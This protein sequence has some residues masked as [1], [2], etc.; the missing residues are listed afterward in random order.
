MY[1]LFGF[2]NWVADIHRLYFRFKS[3]SC[4][5]RENAQDAL[6]FLM[7]L[8]QPLFSSSQTSGCHTPT[9]R[10][11]KPAPRLEPSGFYDKSLAK[12]FR[13]PFSG[14]VFVFLEK[15]VAYV[16]SLQSSATDAATQTRNLSQSVAL[17][18]LQSMQAQAHPAF[19]ACI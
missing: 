17:I 8:Q 5:K 10:F 1:L 12:L 15:F 2:V 16:R 4:E 13:T 18:N 6:E 7:L 3:R 9:L 11:T 19:R 14:A